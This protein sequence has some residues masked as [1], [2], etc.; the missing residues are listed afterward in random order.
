MTAAHLLEQYHRLRES[1]LE[2]DGHLRQVFVDLFL[3][4]KWI[5]AASTITNA[6]QNSQMLRAGKSEKSQRL[7]HLEAYIVHILLNMWSC[8]W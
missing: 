2:I 7:C 3:H 5:A 4:E 1:C 8:Q 6:Y